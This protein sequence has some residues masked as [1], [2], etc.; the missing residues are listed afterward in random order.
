[1]DVHVHHESF[2]SFTP[3]PPLSTPTP[4]PTTEATNPLSVLPDFASIFQINNRVSALENKVSKLRK[5][6]PLKT[7]VTAL[8]DEHLDSRLGATKDEFMSY[9]SASITARITE[10]VKIQLLQILPKEVSNFSPSDPK[11]G[12]RVT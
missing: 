9:L 12:H 6:D 1:M 11:D 2:P 5:D 8:V 3:Q 7:Q 10:Q 4:P